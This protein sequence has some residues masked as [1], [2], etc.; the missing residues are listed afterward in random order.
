MAA[1]LS[2][3]IQTVAITNIPV[4][5]LF[6][7]AMAQQAARQITRSLG[8]A[9][10]ASEEVVLAVAELASNMVRH[11]GSGILTLRPLDGGGRTG[12]EVEAQD[13]GPGI[14]DLEQAFEDGYSTGG[15]LGYGLGSVNRLMDEIEISST[16]GRGTRVLS[17]RWLRPRA[18]PTGVPA[19]QIGVATRARHLA[20]ANGDAF[21]IRKWEA[22]LLAGVIDGLGHGEAAQQA[23]LAAQAYVQTHYD[24]PLDKLFCGVSRVCRGTRGVVMAL[25]RFESPVALTLAT[26]GNI[27]IR[28][29][30][31]GQHLQMTAQRGFLGAQE[32]HVHVQQLLWEPDW[33]F[34]LH[35]DGLRTHWQWSD[36]PGLERESPRAV[37]N[38][39]LRKL[40]KDD[41]DATVLAVKTL[42]P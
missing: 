24:L 40:A 18:D 19:W 36:F 23:A 14:R 15:G 9:E 12:I 32:Y 34:V 39:L 22:R 25:A 16:A 41:D 1:A 13:H 27:E 28:P 7:C 11:A 37:A 2:F 10:A 17:R 5:Q 8:F 35:S 3:E 6:D 21:V 33:I 38:H 30:T 4:G 42:R 26:L 29:W 31:S 20:P